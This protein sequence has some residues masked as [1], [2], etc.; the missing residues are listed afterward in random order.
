LAMAALLG[1]VGFIA[2]PMRPWGPGTE[3]TSEGDGLG[4]AIDAPEMATTTWEAS[5][6]SGAPTVGAKSLV[7]TQNLRINQWLYT[8]RFSTAKLTEP[9]LGTVTVEPGSKVRVTKVDDG[10]HW[11]E[12]DKGKIQATILSPPKLFFVET[13]SATAV[14]MGCAYSL[15]VDEKGTGVLHVTAGWVEL[16]R[17]G[18]AVRVPRGTKC[19]IR[20]GVGPGTPID[21]SASDFIIAAVERFDT[22]AATKSDPIADVLYSAKEEDAITLWHVLRLVPESRRAEVIDKLA[23][24][25]PLPA[26]V[27]RES[28]ASLDDAAMEKWWDKVR[29]R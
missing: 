15:E 7:S 10:K 29:Y 23:A 12:L 3:R 21:D 9:G 28:V 13:R 17:E 1:I 22:G 6:V 16:Q 5:K 11:L 20:A 24:F 4:T 19:V 25:V 2:W 14:D 18:R 27:T 26:E 8:D